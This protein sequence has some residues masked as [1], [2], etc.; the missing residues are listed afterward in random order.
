MKTKLTLMAVSAGFMALFG[1]C[2]A[3]SGKSIEPQKSVAIFD[4][5]TYEG[6]DDYYAANP[7]ADESSFYNPILPGCSV[8]FI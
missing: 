1:S 2:A 6:N 8:I 7:L 3:T 5:F 4:S